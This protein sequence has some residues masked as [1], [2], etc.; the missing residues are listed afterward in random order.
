MGVVMVVQTVAVALMEAEVLTEQVR[1][2][3]FST[4]C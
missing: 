4:S 1:M 2:V 3:R